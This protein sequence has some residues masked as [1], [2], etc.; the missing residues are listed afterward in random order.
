MNH[1]LRRTVP[2]GETGPMLCINC[3]TTAFF[4]WFC[5]NDCPNA[6]TDSDLVAA[7]H[8]AGPSKE[9]K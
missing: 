6:A 3:N 4:K 9:R 8:E 1:N 5:E 7:V 2:K